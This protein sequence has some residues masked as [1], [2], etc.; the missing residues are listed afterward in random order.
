MDKKSKVIVILVN[1]NSIIHTKECIGSILHSDYREVQIVV[2]DNA[3]YEKYE[4]MD[5]FEDHVVFI[6]NSE[7]YGFA[8]ANNIGINYAL[9]H[10][11]EFIFLL[12]NDTILQKNCISELV[13]E[14]ERN[15]NKGI[16]TGKILYYYNKN[17]IWYA[18]GYISKLKG[19]VS[20]RGLNEIDKGKYDDKVPCEF[21]SGCCMMIPVSIAQKIQL[22]SDYFLYYE[23]VDFCVKIRDANF[24]IYYSS[25]AVLYH[26][27]SI[28]TGKKS[29]IYSYYFT[30]NRFMFI[31][32]NFS[33]KERIIPY[34]VTF[35]TLFKRCGLGIFFLKPV[36]EG[37]VDF[38][39]GKKGKCNRNY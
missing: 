8:I 4:K 28:S 31:Q 32:N 22:S 9:K 3:S 20:I 30:R 1:Y 29:Y 26:K 14:C 16:A 21:A 6:R 35:L 27:E 38:C 36:I 39:L 7:N 13:K 10:G 12:N 37:M 25:D 5:E 2:V 15:G 34:V 23:D 24:N 11:A 19:D 18:G 17:I 33:K